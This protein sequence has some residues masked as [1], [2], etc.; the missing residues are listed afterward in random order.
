MVQMNL[1]F[2]DK[3]VLAV[4][5]HADDI[6]FGCA[7]SIA[8]FVRQGA[9]VY[10]FIL[11]DGSKGSED[12]SI[13]TKELIQTRETEQ[14]NAAKILGVEKVYFGK[15]TDGELANTAP[16]RH[17]IVRLVRTLKPD[18][19]ITT[20]P[21]MIYSEK[22]GF[23]NHPD[24]RAAGHAALDS[25]FP[26][27]RN[28][29]TFPELW[30]EGLKSHSV[31]DILLIS[32]SGEKANYFVDISDTFDLKIKALREHKSQIGDVNSL[33]KSIEER[34]ARIGKENK[35]KFAESFVHIHLNR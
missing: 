4:V 30:D 21:T 9:K 3:V 5:A 8:S 24:H 34:A 11:T 17:K 18:I 15:F 14:Q 35:V 12:L 32:F 19:V 1:S 6:D 7:G 25:V 27:A 29:R 26:F 13:T 16:V 31:L 2:K 10:Y 28:A 20:D 22:Y 23:I 33:R